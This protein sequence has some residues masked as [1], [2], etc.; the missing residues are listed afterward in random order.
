MNFS[1]NILTEI[2]GPK[3]W[4][5]ED[6]LMLRLLPTNKNS[7]PRPLLR[8]PLTLSWIL[9]LIWNHK[10]GPCSSPCLGK[11]IGMT[12]S[13][14]KRTRFLPTDF[15]PT[16]SCFNEFLFSWKSLLSNIN[17]PLLYSC[18]HTPSIEPWSAQFLHTICQWFCQPST[19]CLYPC[20]SI[21]QQTMVKGWRG[22]GGSSV[23]R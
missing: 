16:L 20:F 7:Q 9:R 2:L 13:M 4:T 12:F 8:L 19:P 17:P 6:L 23:K 22:A 14:Q 1:K 21:F 15:C 10:Q 18:W 3:V 5:W 11:I